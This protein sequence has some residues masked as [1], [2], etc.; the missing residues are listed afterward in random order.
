M[1]MISF[2]FYENNV[3]SKHH[4]KIAFLENSTRQGYLFV[5]LTDIIEH[6]N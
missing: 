3:F 4:S 5:L 6:S 1:F 2:K